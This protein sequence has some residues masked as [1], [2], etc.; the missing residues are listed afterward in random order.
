MDSD[1]RKYDGDK[2][3][4]RSEGIQVFDW[5]E[6]MSTELQV[7]SDVP[8]ETVRNLVSLAVEEWDAGRVR[9]CLERNGLSYDDAMNPKRDL[10]SEE[11][12]CVG[13]AAQASGGGKPWFKR[14]DLG[15]KLGK[16]VLGVL[17]SIPGSRTET[18]LDDLAQWVEEG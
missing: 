5:N 12:R 15:E 9:D 14:I 6:G 1:E 11:R 8:D 16:I 18:T 13:A 17:K 2:E 3:A 10:T 4:L 7:F